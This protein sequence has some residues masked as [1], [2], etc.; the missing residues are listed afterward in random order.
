MNAVVGVMGSLVLLGFTLCLHGYTAAW[1]WRWFVV[2]LHVPAISVAHGVGLVA[3][4]ALLTK[5]FRV[6]KEPFP[7]Y[8][9]YSIAKALATLALGWLV[10]FLV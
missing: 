7:K 9:G 6:D 4:A 2:P 1:L 8:C 3:L 10:H 5:Q